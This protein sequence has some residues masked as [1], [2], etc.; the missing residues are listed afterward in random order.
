MKN[1]KRLMEI[2]KNN[3]KLEMKKL[4]FKRIKSMIRILKRGKAGENYEQMSQI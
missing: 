3:E 1:R 2:E 4:R